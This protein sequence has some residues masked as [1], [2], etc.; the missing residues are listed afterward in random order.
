MPFV[1]RPRRCPKRLSCSLSYLGAISLCGS[2][3]SAKSFSGGS[4]VIV[5]SISSLEEPP[6]SPLRLDISITSGPLG[7]SGSNDLAKKASGPPLRGKTELRKKWK[8]SFR[9]FLGIQEKIQRPLRRREARGEGMGE[10]Q[11]SLHLP[12]GRF[13]VE[14][15][16]REVSL[17]LVHEPD[18]GGGLVAADQT[19]IGEEVLQDD[20]LPL[21]HASE[22]LESRQGDGRFGPI[23]LKGLGGGVKAPFN[24]RKGGRFGSQGRNIRGAA[25]QGLAGKRGHGPYP[26][27]PA[28]PAGA[29]HGGGGFQIGSFLDGNGDALIHSSLGLGSDL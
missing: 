18:H 12:V 26:R 22:G 21:A 25:G 9:G 24:A 4:E 11:A 7:P 29:Q 5:K 15:L 2:Y 1:F 6:R 14:H 19:Q 10:G 20:V 27:K 13:R 3:P 16:L 28:H 23:L 8:R 17:R